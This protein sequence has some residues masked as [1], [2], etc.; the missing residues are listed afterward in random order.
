[1]INCERS[2]RFVLRQ[3]ATVWSVALASAVLLSTV[4]AGSAW[5]DDATMATAGEVAHKQRML[6]LFPD[7]S[8]STQTAPSVIPPL[9]VDTDPSGAIATYQP[10]GRTKTSDSAFFQNLGTNGRTCFTCHQPQDGWGLSAQHAQQ[11][12]AANPNDPLFRLVDGATC[13]SDNVSTPAA[14]QTAYSLLTSKGLI[15][16]GLPMQPTMQFQIVAVND[17]YGCSTNPTTGLTGVQS[18]IASFYRRPLQS[19]NLGFLSTIM[20]DGREPDL[21]HQSVDATLGHAQGTTPPTAAQQAQIVAFEGCATADTPSVCANIPA[22]TGLFTAQYSDAIAGDLYDSGATGGPVVLSQQVLDFFIGENDPFGLNPTGAPFD[23]VIFTAFDAWANLNGNGTTTLA[24]EAIAR[25]QTVFNTVPINITGVAGINDAL[26]QSFVVG[27]CGTCHDTPNAGDH[28]VKAPLNIG[29][30][31]AGGSLNPVPPGLD[32]SGLPV[33]TVSCVAGP[34]AGQSYQVTDIGRAMISGKCADVGKVK[35]P[36][37]RGLAARA[38]YFHN[39]SAATLEQLVDFYDQRFE[40]GL[41]AQQK[42]DL[43]AFLKA[44]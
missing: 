17:P 11:R 18:G 44:L 41:S 5:A 29:V 8:T 13:P 14:M 35:G 9:E 25:G 24:R 15:R 30:A 10:S 1:V 32:I 6:Q 37:L 22:G 7:A 28:S 36:I 3:A 38:P 16:I 39:G 20:W 34:L 19:T 4:V 27:T 2:A 26:G 12:F 40:I 43:V 33:F 23:S 42:S 31:N 21:F